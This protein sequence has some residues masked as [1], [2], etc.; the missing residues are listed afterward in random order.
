MGTGL[1]DFLTGGEVDRWLKEKALL[2]PST[3]RCQIPKGVLKDGGEAGG[4]ILSM[5]AYGPETNLTWPPRPADPKQPWTP[6]WNVRVRTKSTAGAM[7]GMDLA[8]MGGMDGMNGMDKG[9]GEGEA[10][11]A[12]PEDTSKKG[13]AKKL[14]RGLMGGF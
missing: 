2:A 6:E 3:T 13:K 10:E 7:L 1:V 8:G 4:G 9:D 5:I 11:D 12:A 14:L